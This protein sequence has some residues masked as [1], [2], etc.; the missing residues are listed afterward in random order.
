MFTAVGF[1]WLIAALGAIATDAAMNLA[2]ACLVVAVCVLT[3]SR[4]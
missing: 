3:I 4:R 2:A 1:V